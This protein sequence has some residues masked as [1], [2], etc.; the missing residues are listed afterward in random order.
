MSI[1][2]NQ[3]QG[4]IDLALDGISIQLKPNQVVTATHL[5]KLEVITKDLPLTSFTFNREFYCII[6]HDD[7]VS[8]NG[9]LFYGYNEI[10]L[11][12]IPEIEDPKFNTLAQVFDDEFQNRDDIQGEMLQ[13]LLKRLIIKITRLAKSQLFK[14]KNDSEVE[15]IRQY[16]ILVDRHFK[17]HKKVADYAEM[18]H[19]SPKTLANTFSMAHTNTPLQIIH[20]RIVLE[21][22]RKLIHSDYTVKEIA[23]QLGYDDVGSFHKLFKKLVGKSPQAFK[24][25]DFSEKGKNDHLSGKNSLLPAM[26][27]RVN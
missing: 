19:K 1:L 2:W 22:K 6:D 7:E 21:A 16:N 24:N 9:I 4:A 3:S 20:E 26:D 11:V 17:T 15:I 8:C 12:S 13:I 10:P 18:L 27:H 5:Q 25:H 23:F 14:I